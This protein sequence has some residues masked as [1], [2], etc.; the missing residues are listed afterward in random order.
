MRARLE[1][2]LRRLGV[3][4]VLGMGVLLGCAGFYVNAVAPAEQ[5]ARAQH[6]ALE[7]QVMRIQRPATAVDGREEELQRFYGL[8]PSAAQLT[9][10]VERLHGLARRSGLELAQA[11]YRLERPHAGLWAYRV[12]LPVSGSYLQLRQFLAAVLSDM[13]AASVDALRFE[14]RKAADTRLE[15]QV[16][17]TLHARPT[18]DSE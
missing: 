12:S 6:A 16:R 4:G 14:R 15:A 18:G 2:L 5:Q 13:P 10:E 11:E 3:A 17:V 7:R 8:F 1:R 9:D